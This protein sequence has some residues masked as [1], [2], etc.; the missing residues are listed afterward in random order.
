[1]GFFDFIKG[2]GE[3]VDE[4]A[5][6]AQERETS[7]K[8]LKA[9]LFRHLRN[10]GLEEKIEGLSLE[11]SDDKVT[12]GGKVKS[13]D[14]AEIVVLSVGNFQG[15]AGVE[16]ELEVPAAAAVGTP[17][18]AGAVA[19]APAAAPKVERKPTG[20]FH[21]V[22]SGDTLW[23]IA[24][25]HLGDGNKYTAIFEANKPMLKDPDSIYPGQKLRIP[26]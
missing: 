6:E 8:M 1:M 24:E 10:K 15:V 14:I 3:D 12:V 21:T 23:A 18:A 19:A 11:V 17:A 22:E 25:K 4:T 20:V 16:D 26:K 9:K 2:S 5:L 7:D 13:E